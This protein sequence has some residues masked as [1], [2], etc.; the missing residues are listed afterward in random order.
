[1]TKRALVIL[2][3]FSLRADFGAAYGEAT[4]LVVAYASPAAT[5]C[6]GWIARREG[7]FAKYNLDVE[8]VLMQGA[9][10]DMPSSRWPMATFRCFMAAAPRC[11]GRLRP[12]ISM[13]W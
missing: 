4:K 10:A 8:M 12:K 6:P 13:S 3:L 7:I 9:S 11:R 5:F 1:M 2:L